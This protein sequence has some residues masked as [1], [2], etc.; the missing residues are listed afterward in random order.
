MIYPQQFTMKKGTASH[1]QA[2]VTLQQLSET[3]GFKGI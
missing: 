2:S 3:L 1:H